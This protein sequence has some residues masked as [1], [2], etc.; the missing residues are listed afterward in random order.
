MRCRRPVGRKPVGRFVYVANQGTEAK[1]NDTVSVIDVASGKVVKTIHTGAGTHGVVVGNDAFVLVTNIVDG[2]VSLIS[3]KD[4]AVLT[5]Y[6]VGKGPN[7]ITYQ[8][9][10]PIPGDAG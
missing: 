6:A 2:T 9:A 5:S 7:G 1:P 3:V 4:Q 10:G 8:S